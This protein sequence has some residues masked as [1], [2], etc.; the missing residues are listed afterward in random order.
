MV[1]EIVV[2]LNSSM[3]LILIIKAA[4]VMTLGLLGAWIARRGRAAIRHALLASAFGVVLALPVVSWIA[5]PVTISVPTARHGVLPS[6]DF[7]LLPS[8]GQNPSALGATSVQ[9]ASGRPLAELPLACITLSR[10]LL[11]GWLMGFAFCAIPVIR[12]FLQFRSLRRVGL[13][14]PH[15]QAVAE[16]LLRRRRQGE[17]RPR[18][19][20]RRVEVLIH[21]SLPGPMTCGVLRPL[22]MLPEDV[23]SWSEQDLECALIHELE[24]VRRYDWATHCLARV[25]CAAYWFNPLIWVAWRQLTLEAERSCDDAVLRKAEA[26]AYADQLLGL[27]RRRSTIRRSPALAMANRSD[28]AVRIGALLD[29]RQSRGPVSAFLVAACAVFVA[30][31][32]TTAPLRIADAAQ[33]ATNPT[34]DVASVKQHIGGDDR[35][36]LVPPTVL[37]GGR[38]VSKFPLAILISY[39]YKLPF[40]QSERLTGIPDW[41]QGVQGTYD[42]EAAG[43]MPPSL[44]NQARNDRVRAMVQALLVDRF[45]L[46]MR[47]ESRE[48]P[49]Y[50]LLVA[51]GGPKLQRA[52]IDEKDCPEASLNALG[53]VSTSTPTPNVCHAFSGGMGRGL[54]SRASSISDLAAFVENW[55]DR[56]LLDKTG[57]GGLYRFETKGWL[58]M[59]PIAN[60]GSSEFADR[61][62][63]FQIFADLGLR[64]EAQKAVVEVYVVDHIEKPSQN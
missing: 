19:S 30:I 11:Y 24:H 60:A 18:R 20:T 54:H 5:P 10:M 4:A 32:L 39:A 64:M 26:T 51:R 29:H 58:P 9:P 13:P 27:A 57:I 2:T 48:M 37:P 14:W 3:V 12:G 55:T 23:K 33:S 16:R 62:T 49:V 63:V 47:R 22:V 50:A 1:R 38:F 8:L 53:P 31:V 59:G 42:V 52:D 43:A 25:A 44:S 45:K 56:P 7:S 17:R 36:S 40:N 35:N 46:V 41:A 21:E 6:S 28:L 15:G 61:P 34:F